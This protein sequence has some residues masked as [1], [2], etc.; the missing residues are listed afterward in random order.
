MWRTVAAAVATAVTVSSFVLPPTTTPT[1]SNRPSSIFPPRKIAFLSSQP[2]QCQSSHT[3]QV[4]EFDHYELMNHPTRTLSESHVIFGTLLNPNL[5]ERY[6][7]YQ[8][9]HAH[10]SNEIVVADV[11]LGERLNGHEGVVHGGILALLIDDTMGYAFEA[12]DVPHAVTANLHID[13]RLPVPAGTLIII[14]V[15]FVKREGRKIYYKAEITCPKDSSK[16]YAE[17]SS[18]FI[19]PREHYKEED[20]EKATANASE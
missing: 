12:M 13:Y 14:K 18:L 1:T 20:A 9:V 5:L 7:V 2:T 6:H 10:H 3:M 8:R 11:K 19:I 15:F 4:D 16:L 17:A